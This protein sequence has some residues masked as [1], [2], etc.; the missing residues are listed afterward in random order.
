M[1]SKAYLKIV[2]S[3]NKKKIRIK[4]SLFLVEGI[5]GCEELI[6]SN[7]K[8]DHMFYSAPGLS[9]TRIKKLLEI[10]DA[11]KINSSEISLGEMSSISDAVTTQ[12]ILAVAQLPSDPVN[13]NL[14][15][16]SKVICLELIS[17]PGNL[18][19]I[20]RTAAW[21]G[22]D[23]I[24]LSNGSVDAYNPKVV[25]SSSG[26]IFSVPI[27]T[28]V[29]LTNFI[30]EAKFEGFEIIAT[31]PHGGQS[32]SK[33]QFSDKSLLI[34]GSEADGISAP[35]ISAAEALLSI[36][37]KGTAESLNLAISCGIILGVMDHSSNS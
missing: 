30:Q 24:A 33:I 8:V 34:F 19:A 5:R 20:I 6:K 36:P 7:F 16:M 18:G 15:K 22:V 17:D 23:A 12:N 27:L 35:I 11:D 14:S 37:S 21:F 29:T 26:S 13:I 2:K 9:D 3:L 1:S 31:V 32:L 28:N 25:R 10:T 4:H